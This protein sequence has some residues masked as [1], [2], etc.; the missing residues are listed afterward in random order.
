ML[1]SMLKVKDYCFGTGLLDFI[2]L[3]GVCNLKIHIF[4]F[5]PS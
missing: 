5:H 2:I 3:Y 1:N 4:Y